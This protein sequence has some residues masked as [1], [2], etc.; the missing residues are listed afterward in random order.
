MHQVVNE[1]YAKKAELLRLTVREIARRANLNHA[2]VSRAL[3]GKPAGIVS[4]AT[5]AKI[6]R[7]ID[8]DLKQQMKNLNRLSGGATGD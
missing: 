2:T 6:F 4:K 5:K 3:H 8:D 7:I 1:D